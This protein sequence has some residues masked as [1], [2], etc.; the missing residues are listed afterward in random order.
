MMGI[1]WFA[2]LY[3]TSK[4][5]SFAFLD[6]IMKCIQSVKTSAI[7]FS[8]LVGTALLSWKQTDQTSKITFQLAPSQVVAWPSGLRRWF[9][10]PVISMAWVRIPPLPIFFFLGVWLC[11]TKI[12]CLSTSVVLC[13]FLFELHRTFFAWW[14]CIQPLPVPASSPNKNTAVNL[15]QSCFS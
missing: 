11:C 15:N 13:S 14:P 9:K 1:I 12:P 2:F 10:A 5:E 8:T 7:Y 6:D 3:S 4:H